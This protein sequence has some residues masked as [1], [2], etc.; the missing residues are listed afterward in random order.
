MHVLKLLA[1]FS[2]VLTAAVGITAVAAER[3]AKWVDQ[4]IR[5]W[6]PT[7]REKRWESI[8]WVSNLSTAQKLAREQKRPVFMFTLDG[9]MN[10][11]R[12]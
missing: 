3:D 5:E 8:G 7:E 6:Q 4:R 10:V 12:C 1:G 9:K 11:G 2:A